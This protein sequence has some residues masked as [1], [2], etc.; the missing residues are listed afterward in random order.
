MKSINVFLKKMSC[1]ICCDENVVGGMTTLQCGHI[2]HHLCVHEWFTRHTTCPL[3]RSLIIRCNTCTEDFTIHSAQLEQQMLFQMK[4][5]DFFK[6]DKLEEMKKNNPLGIPDEKLDKV[7]NKAAVEIEKLAEPLKTLQLSEVPN[8]THA[9]INILKTN[10]DEFGDMSIEEKYFQSLSHTFNKLLTKVV[11]EKLVEKSEEEMEA[12]FSNILS[13][14]SESNSSEVIESNEIPP[15]FSTY[16]NTLP[17]FS[18][19]LPESDEID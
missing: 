10:L 4:Q 7:F 5:S 18:I 14:L 15:D 9:M 12:T 17:E 6:M 3:C 11:E 19:V 13:Q 8:F 1:D 2:F 16:L